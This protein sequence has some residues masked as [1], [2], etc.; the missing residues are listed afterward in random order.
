MHSR[1][2]MHLPTQVQYPHS[3]R[4]RQAARNFRMSTAESEL[5]ILLRVW[6]VRRAVG[7]CIPAIGPG[8][9]SH[10]VA[11]S[12]HFGTSDLTGRSNSMQIR[13]FARLALR[14]MAGQ[15]TLD[16]LMVVRIHQGQLQ[17]SCQPPVAYLLTWLTSSKME[18]GPRRGVIA[19]FHPCLQY[20][21]VWLTTPNDA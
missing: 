21:G 8:S 16:P 6:S 13:F 3:P 4:N 9:P 7:D 17:P 12:L 14:P 1:E 10:A 5:T 11:P 19:A 15:R 2:L 18:V 20:S